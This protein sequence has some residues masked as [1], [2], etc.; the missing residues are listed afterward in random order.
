MKIVEAKEL[1]KY[2]KIKKGLIR[3][4]EVIRAVDGINLEIEKSETLGLVGESGCGKTTTC[5]LLLRLLEPDSGSIVFNGIEITKLERTE[6]QQLRPQMQMIFQDVSTAFDPRMKI[7]EIICEPLVICGVS[8]KEKKERLREIIIDTKI[9]PS[10]LDKYPHQ[11]S[12]GQKQRVGIARALILKPKLL[13]ADE[14]ISHLDVAIQMRILN[15]LKDLKEKH[16]LSYL[17]VAH[18][19]KAV[20]YI[21]NRVA[22]MYLGKILETASC[23]SIFTKPVHP[24]TIALLASSSLQE[25]WLLL[26]GEPPSTLNPPS[27]CRF[28]PRCPVREQICF[29]EEPKMVKAGREH[30]AACH[31]V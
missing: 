20:R 3:G 6:L 16:K 13:I 5:K 8:E 14:P 26:Q 12:T 9:S 25:E 24:Y 1:R 17:F 31:F 23:E 4:E 11:L 21:A 10:L 28:H 2:F 18:D 22:V 19:L 7:E 30:F 27:G 15:L 29:E